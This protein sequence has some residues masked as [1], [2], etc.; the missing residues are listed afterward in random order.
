VLLATGTGGQVVGYAMSDDEG[1][2]TM[3]GVPAGDVTVMVERDG[4]AG[5]ESPIPVGAADF[6][7]NSDFTLGALTG[8]EE[9]SGLPAAFSLGQNYPNPFNPTTMIRYTLAAP[10][11]VRLTVYDMLGR[12]VTTL[13]N[14]RKEAGAY[15][16]RFDASSLAS[17]LYFYRLKAG[18][19]V[20]TRKL[21]LLR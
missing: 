21:L 2:Y 1:A 6:T 15:D 12:E 10:S 20:E 18:A 13:V 5:A 14:E 17:G 3:D 9:E 16:V 8:V 4:Y 11:D 19:F 7:I